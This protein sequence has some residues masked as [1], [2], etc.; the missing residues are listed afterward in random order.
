V[1]ERSDV[2]SEPVCLGFAFPGKCQLG[3]TLVLRTSLPGATDP[4]LQR[5]AP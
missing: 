3:G 2:T 1:E 4:G 5:P